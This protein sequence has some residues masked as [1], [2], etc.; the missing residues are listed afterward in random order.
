MLG[1]G[2]VFI[3]NTLKQEK[4]IFWE[5]VFKSWICFIKTRNSVNVIK[6]NFHAFPIWYNSEIEVNNK[7]IFIKSWYQNGVKTVGD[8]LQD[9]G[10]FYTRD[11]FAQGFHLPNLGTMQYNGIVCAISSF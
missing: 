9:G 2:D 1:F 8:F 6:S 5:D 7:T 10:F 11:A 3:L 4:E